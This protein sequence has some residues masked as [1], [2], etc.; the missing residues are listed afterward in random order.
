MPTT[1]LV[2]G[3]AGFIGSNVVRFVLRERPGWRVVNLDL[4]TYSG[5]PANLTG[6]EHEPRYRFVKGDVCDA[7][8]VDGLVGGCDAIVHLAAESHVDRSI[9]D[10]RPFVVTNVLG[11]HVMLEAARKHRR[12]LVFVSTDEVYGS[13]P[14]ESPEKFTEESP[15]RPNS[16]YAA[17]KAGAD[18]LCRAA[19]ETHGQDVVITRCANNLGPYQFPEKIIPL[20]ATNLI[21]GRRVPVYGDGLNVRDWMHVDDHC[22]AL[23]VV[24][25]KG[26][27]GEVYNIGAGVEKSNL[28]LTR[29]IL[30][31][32]GKGEEWIEF[33]A[34]RPGHD[35]RYALDTSKIERELGWRASR[36]DWPGA[37]ERTVRWYIDNPGWWRA[38]KR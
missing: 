5:N 35:R 4:L 26:R 31:I 33:V 22:E 9:A 37:L 3:G 24:L 34:D 13:L 14:L 11:T 1:L 29:D 21:E 7:G 8:L 16:P 10:A 12:R 27:A 23:L 32:M 28:D 20:F 6:L 19:F 36:S 25:E 18:L 15:I 30:R 38:L 17:S 2:T